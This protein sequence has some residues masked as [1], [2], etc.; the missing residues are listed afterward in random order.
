MIRQIDWNEGEPARDGEGTAE[1]ING[2]VRRGGESIPGD[3]RLGDA[4]ETYLELVERGSAPD[5]DAVG[6]PLRIPLTTRSRPQPSM[7]CIA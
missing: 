6:L 5:P 4:L 7:R 2:G 1:F 3:D